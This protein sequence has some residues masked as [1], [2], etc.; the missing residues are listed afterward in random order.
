L[1]SLIDPSPSFVTCSLLFTKGHVLL[2]SAALDGV[3]DGQTEFPLAPAAENAVE[4]WDILLKHSQEITLFPVERLRPLINFVFPYV[5]SSRFA[6][7]VKKLDGITAQRAG[8]GS[9]AEE[10]ITRASALLD[11]EDYLRSLHEFHEALRLSHSL[12]S[13][14]EAIRVCLQLSALYQHLGL[15]HAAKYYGL[16]ASF[17][18]LRL[19]EDA[20]RRMAAVGLA[21]ASE[22]DYASGAS[23]IFFL[24]F[25]SFVSVAGEYAIAGKKSFREK[26]WAKVDFYA[27]LL[28]RAAK[29][30]SEDCHS[31][32]MEQ[33]RQLDAE[34]MYAAGEDKLESMFASLD[35]SAL[36]SRYAKE[37]IA[38]PFSDYASA[39]VTSWKQLGITW[40]VEWSS[41]YESERHGEALCAVLQI[42]L[43]AFA[44]TEFSP[45]ATEATIALNTRHSGEEEVKQIADNDVLRFSL[46]LDPAQGMPLEGQ[47]SIVYYVLAGCSGMRSDD[48]RVRFEEEFKRGLPER[49]GVYVSPAD[50]FRQF[51]SQADYDGLHQAD[52]SERPDSRATRTWKGMS[53]ISEIHPQFVES[54]AL[55]LIEN[56]YKRSAEMFPRTLRHLSGDTAFQKL[57]SK[58][59]DAG[60]KDWHVLL[61]VG[62]IRLNFLVDAHQPNYKELYRSVMRKGEGADHPLVPPASFDE[63]RLRDALQFS[64]VTTI[65][66]MGFQVHQMTPNFPGIDSFLRRFKYWELDV[67]HADPFAPAT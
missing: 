3:V 57:L 15:Y 27:M 41:N 24:T 11:N 8:A 59:R 7:F 53:D 34:D 22:T 13:Q 32:C 38:V 42:V 43:A 20:L 16:A 6:T 30:V 21:Q 9:L 66:S 1:D 44:R 5:T 45:I 33:L 35:R 56:R 58:L 2:I 63:A 64:K 47:L 55:R 46:Q 39:R 25:K 50:V 10:H 40:R 65:T 28:T 18:A 4:V 36:T 12:E 14:S 37:G 26:Q 31:R 17:A 62:N 23:L 19:P 52:P 51:Y 67:A 61:A 29:I 54:E 48:F 49:I 60:W